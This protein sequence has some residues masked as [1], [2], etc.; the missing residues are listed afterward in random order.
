MLKM[1]VTTKPKL[2]RIGRAFEQMRLGRALQDSIARYAFL[3][4]RESKRV[5]PVDT[6]RLRSSIMTDIGNLR[7]KISPSVVYAGWVH[8][9][10][11][12]MRGRPFM[13]I[14]LTKA[15]SESGRLISRDIEKEIS[16]NLRIL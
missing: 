9:G 4:E 1:E 10:T 8:E 12:Y 16:I 14:G 11:R 2:S 3:I 5:T 13:K 7:A 15:T 6:G